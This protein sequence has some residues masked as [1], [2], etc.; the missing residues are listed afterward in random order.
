MIQKAR[1]L[2]VRAKKECPGVGHSIYFLWMRS[3]DILGVCHGDTDI[4]QS[5]CKRAH[6]VDQ[7]A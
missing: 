2:A 7:G 5:L 1:T 4:G 6:S 3:V